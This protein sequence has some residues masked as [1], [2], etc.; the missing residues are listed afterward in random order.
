M[1]MTGNTFYYH[2]LNI[3]VIGCSINAWGYKERHWN[4]TNLIQVQGLTKL[5]RNNVRLYNITAIAQ[6][7]LYSVVT[8]GRELIDRFLEVDHLKVIFEKV[9]FSCG[10]LDNLKKEEFAMCYDRPIKPD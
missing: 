6:S 9:F 3:C 4:A 8:Q 10:P 5:R 1:K 7:N 2:P